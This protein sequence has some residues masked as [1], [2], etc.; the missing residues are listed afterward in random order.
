[1]KY[2]WNLLIIPSNIDEELEPTCKKSFDVDAL[3]EESMKGKYLDELTIKLICL[4][5]RELF[6]K[7]DNVVQ[8]C[9]N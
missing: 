8:V 6:V 5:A 7:E 3:I 4:K 1:M 2:L 9:I